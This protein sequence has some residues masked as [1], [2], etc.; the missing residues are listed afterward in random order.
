MYGGNS[1]IELD[2]F[3]AFKAANMKHDTKNTG[4]VRPRMNKQVPHTTAAQCL[5]ADTAEKGGKPK[6]F[7]SVSA[8][9]KNQQHRALLHVYASGG[10][11]KFVVNTNSHLLP[12]KRPSQQTVYT[13]AALSSL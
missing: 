8:S 6:R 5:T 12:A 1:Q 7:P 10:Q 3:S 13:L 4:V 11:T 9:L 2:I